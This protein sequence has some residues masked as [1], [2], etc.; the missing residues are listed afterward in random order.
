MA[1][2]AE[3]IIIPEIPVNYEE[4]AD[5]IWRRESVERSTA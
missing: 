5:K 3:A 4:I 1:V 2:G